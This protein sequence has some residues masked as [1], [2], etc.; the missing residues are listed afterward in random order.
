MF[1]TYTMAAPPQESDP[2]EPQYPILSRIGRGGMALGAP[3]QQP[4]L[5]QQMRAMPQAQ[6][7]QRMRDV[8]RQNQ[9]AVQGRQSMI[10]AAQQQAQAQAP[11]QNDRA[12]YVRPAAQQGSAPKPPKPA[13]Q[14]APMRNEPAAYVRPAQQQSAGVTPP[15]PVA[16]MTQAS[17]W[18]NVMS[19]PQQNAPQQPSYSTQSGMPQMTQEQRDEQERANAASDSRP[20]PQAT[21]AQPQPEPDYNKG[22]QWG[23]A[24]MA[25]GGIVDGVSKT[26]RDLGEFLFGQR[27]LRKLAGDGGMTGTILGGYTPPRGRQ[28]VTETKKYV[29]AGMKAKEERERKNKK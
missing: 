14:P 13:E 12:R 17:Y 5:L 19:Q 27:I 9:Q 1:P 2:G 21:P 10:Q 6:D 18:N 11:M 8:N 22:A 23:G 15:Q 26:A 3:Q 7:L 20:V 4:R 16:P 24:K 25:D 29:D 28:D